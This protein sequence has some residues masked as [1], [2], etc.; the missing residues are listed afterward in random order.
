MDKATRDQ[1]MI[2]QILNEVLHPNAE[3]LGKKKVE[4]KANYIEDR[5]K[6]V[7]PCWWIAQIH[8]GAKMASNPVYGVRSMFVE[9]DESVSGN[10]AFS[11]ESKV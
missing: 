11:N 2:N 7:T 4:E 9:L 3:L 8:N 10:V 1:G 6:N 5:V